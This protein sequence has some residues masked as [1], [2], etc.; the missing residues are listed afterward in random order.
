MGTW[1]VESH[2]S[3]NYLNMNTKELQNLN[4]KI[5]QI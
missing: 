3:S 4:E 1:G 5:A 2:S